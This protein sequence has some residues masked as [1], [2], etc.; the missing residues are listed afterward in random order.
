M[1]TNLFCIR[2]LIMM[3]RIKEHSQC[4]ILQKWVSVIEKCLENG[5]VHMQLQLC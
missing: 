3:R 1:H 5:T 2:F 4:K